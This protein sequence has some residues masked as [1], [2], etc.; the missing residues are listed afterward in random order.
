M[1]VF[2]FLL[3]VAGLCRGQMSRVEI[4]GIPEPI[5]Q[6]LPLDHGDGAEQW[7]LLIYYHGTGGRV[8]LNTPHYITGG[9]NFV[10]ISTTYLEKGRL[11]LT[12]QNMEGELRNL[13][14]L[15][16]HAI[17]NLRV[18]PERIYVCGF[19][20]GG[21]AVGEFLGLDP[22]LAG[23]IILGAGV[24]KRRGK[25]PA[26]PL[27]HHPDVFIG[28]G[29]DD[30]NYPQSLRSLVHYRERGCDTTLDVWP[31]TGHSFPEG[32]PPLKLTQWLRLRSDEAG[33]VET[34]KRWSRDRWTEVQVIENPVV[35]WLAAEELLEMP[36]VQAHGAIVDAEVRQLLQTL[37]QNEEVKQEMQH[38]KTLRDILRRELRDR[39]IATLKDVL[40][41]YERLAQANADSR[42]CQ[43]AGRDAERIRHLLQ[44][45]RGK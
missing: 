45:N 15:K 12:E 19:S 13:Q 11:K 22:E 18:D 21:W 16:E 14:R 30:G 24:Y 37:L 7:P 28:V 33:L 29:R 44:A 41:H 5:A 38:R 32:E 27:P 40:P 20:K 17:Q 9:R 4:D 42:F 34:A 3:A 36:F 31:E 39:L 23:G 43:Q 8:S 6:F 2:L 10:L 1:R 35:Q 26:P 25:N